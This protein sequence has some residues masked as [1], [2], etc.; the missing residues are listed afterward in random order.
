[1]EDHHTITN[2]SHNIEQKVETFCLYSAE[3]ENF[4]EMFNGMN[5]LPQNM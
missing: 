5:K 4:D 3:T 2:D 1:M